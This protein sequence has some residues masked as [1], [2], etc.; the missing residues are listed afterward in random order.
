[1]FAHLIDSY[2]FQI[3]FCT[4]HMLALTHSLTLS[5]VKFVIN[6]IFSLFDNKNIQ[7]K[8][9]NTFNFQLVI[10]DSTRLFLLCVS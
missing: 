6:A 10:M 7:E 5:V 1:M 3:Q 2:F 9:H 4:Q 8:R